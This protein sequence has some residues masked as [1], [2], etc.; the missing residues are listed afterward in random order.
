MLTIIFIHF[1]RLNSTCT[2]MDLP[3]LD[4]FFHWD[5]NVRNMEQLRPVKIYKPRVDPRD[6]LRDY[7][8]KQHFRFNKENAT[9]LAD[10]LHLERDNNRGLPLTPIQQVCITLG[11]FAGR[12]FQRISGYCGGVS[13]TAAWWVIDRV[14]LVNLMVEH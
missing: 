5:N 13:Q 11:T 1:F 9:R 6:A 10:M 8:F 12:H 2:H 14:S 3:N 4:P 7:E